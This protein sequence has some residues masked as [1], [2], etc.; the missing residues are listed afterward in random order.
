MPPPEQEAS[1]PPPPPAITVPPTS[2]VRRCF[3]VGVLIT[4]GI[5][6]AAAFL[7]ICIRHS[8]F[9][10][11]LLYFYALPAVLTFVLLAIRLRGRAAETAQLCLSIFP[12]GIAIGYLLMF[13]S[14]IRHLDGE[15]MFWGLLTMFWSTLGVH[16][17]IIPFFLKKT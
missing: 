10:F 4:S 11:W 17:C 14:P 5:I 6:A 2:R 9:S 13:N 8:M 1:L 16:L 12:I 3:L 15:L 7:G